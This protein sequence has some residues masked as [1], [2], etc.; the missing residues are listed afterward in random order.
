MSYLISLLKYWR[1]GGVVILALIFLISVHLAQ[2]RGAELR[3]VKAALEIQQ[4]EFEGRIKMYEKTIRDDRERHEFRKKQAKK[5]KVAD[6]PPVV[7]PDGLRAAYDSL[8]ERQAAT[9]AGSQLR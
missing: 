5:F 2:R 7:L 3:E 8:R 1:I 6:N 9:R 4:R